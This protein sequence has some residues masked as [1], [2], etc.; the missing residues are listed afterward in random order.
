MAASSV[1]HTFMPLGKYHYFLFLKIDLMGIGVMIFGLTLAAVYIG[2]HNYETERG[3]I[4]LVMG[5]LMVSNLLIQMTPC[6]AEER[7]D[8]HRIVFYVFALMLCLALA[9][10]GRFVYATNEEVSLF[11]G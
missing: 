2:F 6:Y 5:S 10:S 4:S 8:Y 11:Y 9:I 1:Y 7:F 3:Y